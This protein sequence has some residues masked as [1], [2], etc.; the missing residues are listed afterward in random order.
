VMDFAMVLPAQMRTARWWDGPARRMR[1]KRP[2]CFG[3]Y[4]SWMVDRLIEVK[5]FGD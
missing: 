3:L 2:Q 4:A 1:S 5:G